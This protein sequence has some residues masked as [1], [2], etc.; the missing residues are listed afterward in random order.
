VSHSTEP[1]STSTYQPRMMVSISNA[2]E[3]S[4]SAG[5]WKR[6]HRVANGASMA[7]RVRPDSGLSSARASSFWGAVPI[8]SSISN[9]GCWLAEASLSWDLRRYGPRREPQLRMGALRCCAASHQLRLAQHLRRHAMRFVRGRD[10]AIEG[11]QQ[12]DL[13]DLLDAAS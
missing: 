4:R 2:H 5:H 6:K 7:K 11:H 12:Q 9:A 3:V 10:A 13:L 1:V 8:R